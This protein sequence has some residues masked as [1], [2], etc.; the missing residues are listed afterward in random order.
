MCGPFLCQ[1]S[2]IQSVCGYM[3]QVK[4]AHRELLAATAQCTFHYASTEEAQHWASANAARA[5]LGS[6]VRLA[7]RVCVASIATLH[8]TM[9]APALQTA[10]VLDMVRLADAWRDSREQTV[11]VVRQECSGMLVRKSVRGWRHAQATVHALKRAIARAL[12]PMPAI[13]ATNAQQGFSERAVKQNA[14]P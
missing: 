11:A 10:A 13:L 4:S 3:L 5:L 1:S 7:P 12:L 9:V 2:D 14:W 8:A 6:T